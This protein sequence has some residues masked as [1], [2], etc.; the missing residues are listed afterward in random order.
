MCFLLSMIISL[1]HWLLHEC[2]YCCFVLWVQTWTKTMNVYKHHPNLL[3]SRPLTWTTTCNLSGL[4][5]HLSVNFN[6]S[7]QW[8]KKWKSRGR[9]SQTIPTMHLS[10]GSLTQRPTL[11]RQNLSGDYEMIKSTSQCLAGLIKTMMWW[12]VN[13]PRLCVKS[14]KKPTLMK[15]Q[16]LYFIVKS[17]THKHTFESGKNNES[18]HWKTPGNELQY[19]HNN[20]L[21]WPKFHPMRRQQATNKS[22]WSVSIDVPFVLRSSGEKQW[23]QSTHKQLMAV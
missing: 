11:F 17:N 12:Q 15:S 20:G 13:I 19:V 7:A 14:E 1:L 9:N 23:H 10:S 2:S 21:Y 6:N 4:T 18:C 8:K 22:S 5:F 16:L 3:S